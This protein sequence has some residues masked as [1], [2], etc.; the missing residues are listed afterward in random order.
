MENLNVSN[1]L[2]YTRLMCLQ[3]LRE[4]DEYQDKLRQRFKLSHNISMHSTVIHLS[5]NAN[6]I[7]EE[8]STY[9]YSSFLSDI[10]GALGKFLLPIRL[11]VMLPV[12]LRIVA[13][14]EHYKY[15]SFL[16][17]ALFKTNK[18]STVR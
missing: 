18:V 9:P 3:Y 6:L 7:L 10:G 14:T 8:T 2:D 1:L 16:C 13:W 5:E 15:S 4:N 11:P 17:N 12:T